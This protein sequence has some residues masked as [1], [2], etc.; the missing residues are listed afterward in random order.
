MKSLLAYLLLFTG[1]SQCSDQPD[2][3]VLP[4]DD[5]VIVRS[6]TS[7]GM[8]FG[9]CVSEMELVGSKATFTKS[10]QRN[11]AQYPNKSCQKVLAMDKAADLKTLALS[12][13]DAFL[14]LPKTIGCP[15]CADGG[16]EYIE[17]QRGDVRY[18]VTFEYGKSIPNFESLV[19]GLRTQRE[20]FKNCE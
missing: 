8:C 14:R 5:E 9:Y 17:M 12:Q 16:A 7:F 2:S 6:G 15:D 3:A 1:I 4:L 19:K 20:Q 13:F 10:S 11:K 18:R